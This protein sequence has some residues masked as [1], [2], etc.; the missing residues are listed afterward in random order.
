MKL[1]EVLGFEVANEEE[2]KELLKNRMVE[3]IPKLKSI[4][5]I[6]NNGKYY[7]HELQ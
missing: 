3:I 6:E 1:F 2:E 7:F 4:G 5:L